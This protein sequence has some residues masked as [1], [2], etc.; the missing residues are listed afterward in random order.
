MCGILLYLDK[1]NS[2]EK[3]IS[4]LKKASKLLIHRGPDYNK[5]IIK[6]NIYLF[7]SRLSI[8]DLN[9]R[10]NQPMIKNY[11]K[12]KFY[13][14]YN[15]EIYNFRKIKK[16]LNK[17]FK[18]NTNSD[19]EVL[20]NNF[21]S[22]E[23]KPNF[24]M[25][26]K[27]M[28][29]FV[30]LNSSKKEILFGRDYF[31]QKPLY[32]Y[33]DDEKTIISSEIK[34]ILYI[35]KKKSNK[36]NV[37]SLERYFLENN[38]F[39]GRETFF[40][41]IKQILPGE[42]GLISNN[43]IYFRRIYSKLKNLK[44]SNNSKK[45]Y[46]KFLE[47]NIIDHTISDKKI[48]LS[49]SAG[50]DSSLIAHVIYTY[51]KQK[52]NLTAYTFDF[53]NENYEYNE[54]KKFV[55]SYNEQ[56]KKIIVSKDY[57]IENFEKFIKKNEGPIG[58]IS[59]FGLF[60]I[61]DQAKKDGFDV[62]LSGYGLDE[63]FGSYKSIK[64]SKS[65]KNF[66]LIDIKNLSNENVIN[67]N[68]DKLLLNNINDY[69]FKIK[70]PRTTHMVDRSSMASSVEMRIPF[71]EKNFVETSVYWRNYKRKIDKLL[72][73]EYMQKNSKYKKNWIHNKIHVPHPQNKWLRDGKLSFWVNE[74]INDNYLYKKID[75][76]NKNKL[77]NSWKKFKN[78]EDMNGYIFWQIINIYF[79]T[80][81][82]LNK[83]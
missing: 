61:C 63:C 33:N 83:I 19:T 80:K 36:L 46:F 77:L 8:Q 45:N 73:R 4:I 2:L 66:D 25:D 50:L 53:E 26:F 24:I 49:L 40:E 34:P 60:K 56:I 47:K 69:F 6:N 54:A 13:T 48:S 22:H 10:S 67:D 16:K 35:N 52:Y 30:I 81:I 11:K 51:V 5:S 21:L 32:F 65:K 31:G 64:N 79:L 44:I 76:I 38:Y 62:M 70:I 20:I 68:E 42:I 82:D 9:K 72:I 17:K 75:F 29:A 37:K 23:Q 39:S 1:K 57:I 28:F 55:K 15:G 18:F 41:G 27:G 43:E 7:H 58:G 71:L 59:Q 74:I 14:S 12:E 3:K 78:N